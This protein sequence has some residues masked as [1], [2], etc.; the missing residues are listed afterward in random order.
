MNGFLNIIKPTGMT[1]NDLVAKLR[2]K[3]KK[4]Y[5]IKLKVGHTGTLDPNASGVM[6]VA[7][8]QCTKFVQYIIEK[9]KTYVAEILLGKLTDTLDTYG[10]VIEEKP[11]KEFE[12]EDLFYIIKKFIGKIKQIPPMYSAIKISGQRL[13][14]LA[15]NEKQIEIKPRDI[16]I[17]NI[18]VLKR[19]ENKILIEVSC[20]SGTYIRSL[21]RDISNELE[22]LG[23][24]SFL[25]RTKVDKFDIQESFTL[26]EIERYIE[27]KELEKIFL[28]IDEVLHSYDKVEIL[29]KG[30][31]LYTNGARINMRKYSNAKK[32]QGMYRVY[33]VG[34]F[35]GLGE[36]TKIENDMYIKSKTILSE[37]LYD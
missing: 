10:K 7:L 29:K 17:K 31:K 30:E 14:K 1:S 35:L 28:N 32:E 12:E 13:Y 15:R 26:E 3:I 21:A 9:E 33:C 36:I 19:D 16:E 27:N 20:S 22:N 8:G 4:S 6:I 23:I 25:I 11:I 18:N 34:K 2:S 37:V 5:N 24:L